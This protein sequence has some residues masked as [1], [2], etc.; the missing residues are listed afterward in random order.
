VFLKKLSLAG[1]RN[2]RDNRG[3]SFSDNI[4]LILGPNTSGKTNLL[5]AVYLLSTGDSFRAEKVSQ[6]I[7]HQDIVAHLEAVVVDDDQEIKLASVISRGEIN[8]Q[9]VPLRKFSVNGVSRQQRNFAGSLLTVLFSPQNLDIVTDSPSFRRQFLNEVLIQ[10]DREYYRA[11]L[12]YQKG[13]RSRNRVLEQI[14]NRQS[15][16]KALF[17]WD[18]L[19]LENG[20]LIIKKREELVGFINQQESL[21]GYRLVYYPSVISPRKLAQRRQDEIAAAKTLFGP[22]RDDFSVFGNSHNL[23]IFGSRGEQRLSVLWLKLGQLKFLEQA[24]GKRPVLLL[25]DIFSELDEEHKKLV[26]A[27]FIDHQT[28]VTSAEKVILDYQVK[29]IL[30]G[31]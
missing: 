6:M 25:D 21:A 18:R 29:A 26:V 1:F 30:L 5:E 9:R 8:G 31:E 24:T 23:A 22:H 17:F 28:L 27:S 20:Q 3:F 7:N 10:V 15:S 19:L 12:S 16:E 13:V 4:N 14:R 2:Y 11:Y